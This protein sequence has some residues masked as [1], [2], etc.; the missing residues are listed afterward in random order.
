MAEFN[1]LWNRSAKASADLSDK[2]YHFVRND[3]AGTVNVSSQGNGGAAT[4]VGVLQ[5]KP[6]ADEAATIG[7]LGETKLVAG[8]SVAVNV[9]LTSDGTGR[10]TA[11]ASG[12]LVAGKSLQAAGAAAEVF[13]AE[14]F[15]AWKLTTSA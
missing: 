11:A 8:G 14:V 1:M 5:N 3:A 10:A 6:Q 15:P 13:R 12:D 7:M 9:W 2:Q 4:I